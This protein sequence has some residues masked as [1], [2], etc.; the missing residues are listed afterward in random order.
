AA[1]DQ[2]R[3]L[4]GMAGQALRTNAAREEG[5]EARSA[6]P[7]IP[8]PAPRRTEADHVRAA[9]T[10]PLWSGL[11]ARSEMAGLALR[12][13]RSVSDENWPQTP[14]RLPR[15]FGQRTPKIHAAGPPM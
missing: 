5:R 10:P 8:D 7:A 4:S 15:H 14:E 9:R 13:R 1:R 12:G 3:P 2:G 11:W 6:R